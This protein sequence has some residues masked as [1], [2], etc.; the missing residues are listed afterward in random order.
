MGVNSMKK[1]I[2]EKC[3]LRR[4]R[5]ECPK[6][7]KHICGDCCS[8]VQVNSDCPQNCIHLGKLS[9]KDFGIR[10]GTLAQNGIRL[11]HKSPTES[12]MQFDKA[13]ELDKNNYKIIIEKSITYDSIG[14]FVKSIECL[15]QAYLINADYNIQYKIAIAYRKINKFEECI[16]SILK[17]KDWLSSIETD[18][19]LGDCYF[20][21][22]QYDMAINNLE[23]I[24]TNIDCEKSNI[25]K[26]RVMLS[27]SYLML[28]NFD[29]V[30]E[31]AKDIDM[32]YKNE[33]NNLIESALF[34]S[35]RMYELLHFIN[36]MD[37]L[38]YN[39]KYMMLQC[40][41]VLKKNSQGN[42]I[43]IIDDILSC[44]YFS[45]DSYEG[46]G[47]TGIKIKLLFKEFKM[48]QAYE[49]FIK[50]EDKIIDM[51]KDITDCYESCHL[52]AFFLYNF[53]KNKAISIYKAITGMAVDGFII[54]ELYNVFMNMDIPP[55]VRAKAV[56][57]TIE[58][59]KEGKSDNF[60]RTLIVGDILFEYGEYFQAYE[61]YKRITDNEKQDTIIMYKMAICLMKQNKFDEALGMFIV[62]V[63]LTKFIAGVYPGII[64]CC[65]ELN[66]EWIE[67]F[68]LLELEKL[69]FSEIYELAGNLLTKEYY[70]KAGYLYNYML[71]KF[72]GIDIYSKKMIYHNMVCVYRN[73]GEYAKGI[74]IIEQIGDKY[75]NEELLLD[76]GCLYFDI[77]QLESAKSIFEK[78][79]ENSK[80]PVIYFNIGILNMKSGD[81]TSALENFDVSI[82]QIISEIRVKKAPNVK[83]YGIMLARLYRN[84]SLCY[85]KLNKIKESLIYIEKALNIEN[86]EKVSEILFIIQNRHLSG[87]KA[88]ETID[89]NIRLLM[90]NCLTVKVTFTEDI[91]RL[92]DSILN[93]LYGKP[94]KKLYI[95]GEIT[96]NLLS[97]IR[98]E[99]RIYSKNMESIERSEGTFQRYVDNL[100]TSF[101]KK[102]IS[103]ISKEVAV[104][105]DNQTIDRDMVRYSKNMISIADNLFKNFEYV[106][107]EE[108]IY[109]S[110][111][112]Y[113]K[114]VKELSRSIIYPYYKSK[115]NV[116]PIPQ[117]P[118]D[119]KSIGVYSYK[120]YQETSLRIDYSFNISSSEYLF[121][122]NCHPGLRSKYIN[123]EKHY[124]PWDKLLW[125]ISGIKKKW[126]IVDDAKS[127]GLLLLFY[128]G[129]KNYL[130]IE[131]SFNNNDEIINLSGDLI[132]LSNERDYYIRTM[133]KN[134]YEYDY[135]D[136]VNRIRELAVRCIEGLLKINTMK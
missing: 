42:I 15:K 127:A 134:E 106:Q 19:L 59:I 24:I 21:T 109:A 102:V 118:E 75:Y 120:S 130:G 48:K 92:L 4:G 131:S 72:K 129:Y 68:K 49:L 66:N 61:F 56:E 125:M 90:D 52:M 2:C 87:D 117:S 73:L 54:D 40:A 80:N 41:L 11:R 57:K 43:A 6:Y 71:E 39:E 27:R 30:I 133:L 81:Y 12:I 112:P 13:L 45:Q 136:C 28:R 46:I 58:L 111:I 83:E 10:V 34:T 35:G 77:G 76:M 50:Y 5:R 33:K 126:D 63:S 119:F 82:S 128:S 26:A 29:K 99:K 47:L 93:R 20:M 113:Y 16:K 8:S 25:N 7:N 62:I 108:F 89:D 103:D 37:N 38:G 98:N 95:S 135:I 91:R 114:V 124:M 18:Y 51:A 31:N 69:S 17:I 65:L 88:S 122:I 105:M 32:E 60:N 107:Y 132:H 116:L 23:K 86:N 9:N 85:I 96:D 84:C 100:I 14:E 78:A 67:F 97:F 110:L 22:G 74:E 121:D 3:N 53:D 94:D 36:S 101:E 70:D 55:F 104:T 44:N 79:S 1:I 115:I 123:F 64:K